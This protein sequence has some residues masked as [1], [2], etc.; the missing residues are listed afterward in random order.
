MQHQKST[1]EHLLFNPDVTP[2][3]TA[4]VSQQMLNGF[5]FA[6]N[7]A[8]IKVAENERRSSGNRFTSK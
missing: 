6:V 1:Q 8:L 2:G 7:R 4:T 3:F 5:G